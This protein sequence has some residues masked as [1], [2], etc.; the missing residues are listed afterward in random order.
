LIP[1]G[2]H[3]W[4]REPNNAIRNPILVT[5]TTTVQTNE[6]VCDY[7]LCRNCEV[8]FQQHGEDWLM[9][10]GPSRSGRFPLREAL[11][12]SSNKSTIHAG[13][14]YKEPFDSAFDLEQLIYFAAS[15]FWRSSVHHWQG[16]EHLMTRA[17][18]ADRLEEEF[19]L[20]LFHQDQFPTDVSLLI[21]VTAT[22]VYPHLTHPSAMRRANATVP[23]MAGYAFM[24]PGLQFRLHCENV[25][26]GMRS[27]S[28]ALPPH[29]ILVSDRIEQE[30]RASAEE[31]RKTSRVVGSLT[32]LLHNE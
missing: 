20:F 1:Q 4:L 14:I 21:S 32:R 5:A 11:L 12:R 13:E 26:D 25:P 29:A 16:F 3:R 7:L 31:L 6:Q 8:R 17:K 2:I 28:V 19:R 18:L 10:N 15:I 22:Q 30:I 24:I 9:K 23:E 27:V